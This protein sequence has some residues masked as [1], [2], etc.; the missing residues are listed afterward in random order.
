VDQQYNIW[1]L[2]D[3]APFQDE[4]ALFTNH[5]SGLMP[6]RDRGTYARLGITYKF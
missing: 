2:L 3:G 5:F 4:R 1:F 6:G